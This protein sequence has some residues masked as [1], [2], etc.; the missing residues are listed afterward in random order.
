[1]FYS[2]YKIQKFFYFIG[3]IVYVFG[4]KLNILFVNFN[5]FL[6]MYVGEYQFWL[7]RYKLGVYV[8]NILGLI[9]YCFEE[10]LIQNISIV[11]ILQIFFYIQCFKL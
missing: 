6:L 7:Y 1:M 11:I 8:L 3:Y 5:M 2:V 10:K 9:D 4:E